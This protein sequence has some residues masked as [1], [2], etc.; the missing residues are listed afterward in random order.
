MAADHLETDTVPV[1]NPYDT[2]RAAN[3]DVEQVAT[4]SDLVLM[5]ERM[6]ADFTDSGKDEWENPT[7][8]RYLDALAAFAEALPA[9]YANQGEPMPEQP[10]WGL[11]AL[12]LA[13]AT[14]YE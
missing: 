10:T 3:V 1:V 13:G 6:H 4:H 11:V 5:L 14:G 7:L 8:D 2:G 9:V 12:L